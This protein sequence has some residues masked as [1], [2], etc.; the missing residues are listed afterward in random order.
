[1]SNS[2]PNPV[3]FRYVHVSDFHFCVRPW[4][5]NALFKRDLHRTLD[6][7]AGKVPQQEWNSIFQPSSYIP[8]VASGVARFCYWLNRKFDGII[9]SGDLSTTGKPGDLATARTFI[10]DPPTGQTVYVRPNEATIS[11]TI[12]PGSIHLIPG[13][14][15]RYQNDLGRPGSPNFVL[16]FADKFMRNFDGEVGHWI[17]RKSERELGF[18]YADFSLRARSDATRSW[19]GAYGQGRVYANVLQKLRNKTQELK[20]RGMPV[21]WIIHFAPWDCDPNLQLIGFSQVTDLAASLGILCTLCGHTHEQDNIVRKGH[22]IYCAGSAGCVDSKAKSRVHVIDM[23]IDDLGGSV[24]R[25]NFGWSWDEDA[26]VE[27][28]SD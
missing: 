17:R 27:L 22:Q 28:A 8:E 18:V 6:T 12:A 4:R 10:S 16:M 13:N 5:T 23:S 14:H 9:V 21:V 11:G 24:S 1:M 20:D 26:F 15:D 3:L 2:Q 25:R 7:S 19:V